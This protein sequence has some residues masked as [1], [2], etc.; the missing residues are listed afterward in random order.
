MKSE[1]ETIREARDWALRKL[2]RR[3]CS[4]SEILAHLQRKKVPKEIALKVATDLQALGVLSDERYARL[5][6]RDQALRGKGSRFILQKLKQKGVTLLD[7]KEVD[8][9]SEVATQ[10]TPVQLAREIVLRRYPKAHQGP[11]E[12]RRALQALMRRGFAYSIAQ[13]ALL[14]SEPDSDETANPD[15]EGDLDS[16]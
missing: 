13:E 4:V 9:I 2:N 12:K 5:L 16:A 11:H 8:S 1:L 7:G 6:V 15:M 14:P 3:E 10:K